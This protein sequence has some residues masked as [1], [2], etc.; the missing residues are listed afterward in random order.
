[1]AR[2][3]G[4]DGEPFTWKDE[5]RRHL[6]ARLDALYFHLYDLSRED[7]DYVL[8]TFPIIRRQ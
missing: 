4:Y 8:G 1:M 2:D 7:A 6:Q 3:L 5:E